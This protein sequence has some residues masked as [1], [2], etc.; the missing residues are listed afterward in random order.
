M[1]ACIQV[2]GMQV[3]AKMSQWM[4]DDQV[5]IYHV[6]RIMSCLIIYA[7]EFWGYLIPNNLAVCLEPVSVIE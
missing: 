2:Y 5:V 3:F 4:N 6:S 1:L 7:I